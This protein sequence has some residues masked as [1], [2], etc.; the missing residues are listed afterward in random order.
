[1]APIVAV[2]GEIA[3]PRSRPYPLP[4][5]VRTAAVPPATFIASLPAAPARDGGPAIVEA[6][7]GARVTTT[8][9]VPSRVLAGKRAASTPLP[10]CAHA[11]HSSAAPSRAYPRIIGGP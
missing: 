10:A 8:A 6:A 5:A 7:E 1:M 2:T 9:T 3:M 4:T 11:E